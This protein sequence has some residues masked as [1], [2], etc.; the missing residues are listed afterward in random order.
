MKKHASVS[1]LKN[2]TNFLYFSFPTSCLEIKL[3]SINFIVTT[4]VKNN[5]FIIVSTTSRKMSAIILT[6]PQ[7]RPTSTPPYFSI[8]PS[9]RLLV[10]AIFLC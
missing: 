5:K 7:S 8:S 3:C 2:Y 6:T 1:N 9:T 10:L 4:D